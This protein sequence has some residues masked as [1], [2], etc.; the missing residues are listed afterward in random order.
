MC[1][2]FKNLTP[3]PTGECVPGEGHTRWVERGGG[4]VKSSED[5]RHCS[6]LYKCEPSASCWRGKSESPGTG[7]CIRFPSM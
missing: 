1:G 3:T 4:G 7:G 6:V 5:A 2:V